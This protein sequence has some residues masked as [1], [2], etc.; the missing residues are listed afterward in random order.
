MTQHEGAKKRVRVD[1]ELSEDFEV[2]VAMHQGC[3]L[4]PFLFAVEV[5]VVSK[6]TRRCIN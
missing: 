2:K 6:L 1:S 5:N 4:S 3:V